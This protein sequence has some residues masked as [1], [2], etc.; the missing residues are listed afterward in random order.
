MDDDRIDSLKSLS[1]SVTEDEAYVYKSSEHSK[2]FDHV[3]KVST[4]LHVLNHGPK[5]LTSTNAVN[6]DD[7]SESIM[8]EMV[9]S[10]NEFVALIEKQVFNYIYLNLYLFVKIFKIKIF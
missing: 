8:L 2:H 6:F 5:V 4:I 10:A 1:E 9:Q 7:L 3:V